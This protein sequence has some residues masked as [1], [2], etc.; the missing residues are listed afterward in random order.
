MPQT[1]SARL[2]FIGAGNHATGS[3]YPNLA[4]IPQF[5]LVAVCDL[6]E[7]RARYAARKF[8][9]LHWFTGVGTMLHEVQPDGVCVCGPAEMHHAVSLQ[10]LRRGL[11]TFMEKPPAL[12]L[13]ETQQLAD[14]A[15]DHGTW[16]M[17]AFMKRFAPANVVA[18]E[19]MASDAFG[20]LSSLTLIHSSGPY[21]DLRRM[22]LLNGIHMLDLAR[23]L[24]GEVESLFAHGRT[25]GVQAASVSMRFADGAVGQFNMNSGH[26]WTD[27]FE[28]TYLSGSGA[29][30]LIDASQ[31]T[32]VFA[33]S[34]RFAKGEGLVLY[35]WGSRYHVSG[36]MAGWEAGGHYTRGY[37]G[38]L[39]HFARAVL[40]QVEP[41]PTLADGVAAMAL[42]E[43][44]LQSVESGQPVSVGAGQS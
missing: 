15:R 13:A 24:A 17:V 35:G 30:I 37:W 22:L 16:G 26:T 7:E 20:Q 33:E 38:E 9:A 43:A 5:D 23:F 4:Q 14:A 19:F 8:G 40:G 6:V 39:S 27:C 44:I 29:G 25:D 21:D 11:P 12:T 2:A 41:T 3:L 42:I 18:K 34:S 31:R 36:N 10:T 1:P 32:E 28:Q